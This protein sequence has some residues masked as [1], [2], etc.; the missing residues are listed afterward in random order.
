[1]AAA[2]ENAL[3]GWVNTKRKKVNAT[4]KAITESKRANKR[5]YKGLNIVH[6]HSDRWPSKGVQRHL[7]P[8]R[9]L[10]REVNA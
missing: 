1:M 2:E 7:K 5:A 9:S 10:Y 4:S 6:Q 3:L 8:C